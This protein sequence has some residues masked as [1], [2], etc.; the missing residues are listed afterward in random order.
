MATYIM[1][2]NYTVEG[3]K[4]CQKACDRTDDARQAFR[5]LGVNM[6]E[7]YA[8]SGQYDEIAII[9]APSEEAASTAAHALCSRGNVRVQTLRAFSQEEHRRVLE[10]IPA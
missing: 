6:R 8:V 9:E 3:Q 2:L 10:A 7:C 4:N 5:K 1:L